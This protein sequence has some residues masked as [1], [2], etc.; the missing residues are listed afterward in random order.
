MMRFISP[1][2][3][4]AFKKILGLDQATLSVEE[5]EKIRKQEMYVEDRRGALSLARREAKEEGR[6]E[7]ERGLTLRLFERRFGEITPDIVV[8]IEAL[9]AENLERLGEAIFDFST[10]EYFLNWL[11]ENSN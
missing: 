2:I 8:L 11:Q 4:F 6:I 7:G 10:R 3:D 5:L 1:K 9:N